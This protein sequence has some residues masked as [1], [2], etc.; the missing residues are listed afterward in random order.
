MSRSGDQGRARVP[1]TFGGSPG[2]PAY[3][4]GAAAVAPPSTAAHQVPAQ[5]APAENAALVA[6]PSTGAETASTAAATAL[7]TARGDRLAR[8]VASPLAAPYGDPRRPRTPPTHPFMAEPGTARGPAGRM[9]RLRIGS[10]A[11]SP[12]ALARLSPARYAAGLVLGA[13]R[14]RVPVTLRM[15]H[16]EPSRITL[17]GGVW[18]AQLVA[19]RVLALGARVTVVTTEP[20]VWNALGPAAL[21]R[22]DD[23]VEI[24]TAPG[25]VRP[26]NAQ[27]PM[28]LIHDVPPAALGN[29]LPE[30]PWQTRLTIVRRLE[31]AAARALKE[32]GLC[33]LQRLTAAESALAQHALRLPR[34]SARFLQVMADDMI[35]LVGAA[36]DRHLWLHQTDVE[37]QVLGPPRR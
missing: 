19:F 12:A 31:P 37:H 5:A 8:S 27:R 18:A 3:P 30:Q 26:A 10:H 13:D 36:G 28:L 4:G 21:G 25:E 17:V 34:D 15:F 23:R 7:A 33:L 35:T 11:V 6:A 24:R 14:R 2:N 29:A 9:P 22:A 20:A 16:P 1:A 32:S